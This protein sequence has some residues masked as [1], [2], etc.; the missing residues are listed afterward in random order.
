MWL[1]LNIFFKNSIVNSDKQC[2]YSTSCPLERMKWEKKKVKE[3]SSG[4]SGKRWIQTG[5]YHTEEEE[6][7]MQPRFSFFSV[8]LT[9][10]PLP[11]VFS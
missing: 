4:F 11:F 2:R 7:G 10:M 5:T 9:F 6:G 3:C 8:A 1:I